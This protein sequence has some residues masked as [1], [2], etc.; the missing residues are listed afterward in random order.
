VHVPALETKRLA[1][2]PLAPTHSDGMFLLWSS[3]EVCRYS[4]RLTDR[5]NNPIPAP[6]RTPADSDKIVDFWTNAQEHGWGFRWALLL[7]SS[8]EFVGTT[9]FNSLGPRSEYA[10]H[11]HPDH[12]HEGLMSEASAAAFVWL[13]GV[14]FCTEIEA[15]I[16]PENA[17]SIAFAER[18][19]FRTDDVSGEVLRYRRPVAN[20]NVSRS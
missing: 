15:V 8:R 10:Y 14:G 7:R 13:A 1:L 12:W 18:W 4:G 2:E 16:A 17:N 6:V 19:G 11:L 20:V 3:P 5:H 9:G